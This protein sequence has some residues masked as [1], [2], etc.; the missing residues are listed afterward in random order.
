M[1]QRLDVSPSSIVALCDCGYRALA[2]DRLHGRKLL[3]RH[4][5]ACHPAEIPAATRALSFARYPAND[6]GR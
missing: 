6:Y 4:V 2:S 1:G 5:K 3:L